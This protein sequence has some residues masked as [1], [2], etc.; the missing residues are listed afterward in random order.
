MYN[1]CVLKTHCIYVHCS[2]P[3]IEQVIKISTEEAVPL[4]PT[5]QPTPVM[6]LTPLSSNAST[7]GIATPLARIMQNESETPSDTSSERVVIVLTT[8]QPNENNVTLLTPIEPADT[9]NYLW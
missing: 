7:P 4:T 9:Y 1:I 5:S 2:T 6:S 8:H 3:N